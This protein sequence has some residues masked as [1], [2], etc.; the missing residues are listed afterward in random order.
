DLLVGP[1][2]TAER[3]DE[4]LQL[5]VEELV[6]AS[7]GRIAGA[8]D[9]PV[10]ADADHAVDIGIVA[11]E[12]EGLGTAA[13]ER[14]FIERGVVA[15]LLETVDHVLARIDCDR[16]E[17]GAQPRVY[18]HLT[19]RGPAA[20]F[21][22]VGEIVLALGVTALANRLRAHQANVAEAVARVPDRVVARDFDTLAVERDDIDF[23]DREALRTARAHRARHPLRGE[24]AGHQ[25]RVRV[26]LDVVVDDRAAVVAVV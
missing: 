26:A 11:P 22:P 8:D 20:A 3:G 25:N 4:S 6:K 10:P 1:E 18:R 7:L 15:A 19:E 9:A 24:V 21:R 12:H 14:H 23:L 2:R 17:P 5:G 13:V 16:F